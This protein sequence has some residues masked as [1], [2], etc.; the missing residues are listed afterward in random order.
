MTY[1][2]KNITFIWYHEYNFGPRICHSQYLETSIS[3][4]FGNDNECFSFS[5]WAGR[6]TEDTF[7][8]QAHW[9]PISYAMFWPTHLRKTTIT[10]LRH[11]QTT[12]SSMAPPTISIWFLV[13]SIFTSNVTPWLKVLG[14]VKCRW[15]QLSLEEPVP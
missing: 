5:N 3:T 9:Q 6:A 12:P 4:A 11:A 15:F 7:C 13:P 2:Y 8:T 14:A 10:S 1:C